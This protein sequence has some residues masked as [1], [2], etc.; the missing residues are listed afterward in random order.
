VVQVDRETLVRT[1]K[2]SYH[3]YADLVRASRRD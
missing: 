2:A 3:W 1:P